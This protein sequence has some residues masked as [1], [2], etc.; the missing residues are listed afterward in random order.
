MGYSRQMIE[1]LQQTINNAD[2][3][4]VVVGTPIDLGRFLSINKPVQRAR[5]D[6]QEIG[7]PT[8]RIC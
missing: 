4:V 2:A 8:W 6:L 5:Y 1:E 7:H 3:D